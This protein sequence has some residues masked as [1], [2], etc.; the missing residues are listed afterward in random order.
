MVTAT[1]PSVI[2]GGKGLFKPG[3]FNLQNRK[4]SGDL[5]A[6]IAQALGFS[7]V[8]S[9]GDPAYFNGPITNIRA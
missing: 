3:H 4:T 5:Y 6:T 9:F 2:L 8:T 1:C 7:D